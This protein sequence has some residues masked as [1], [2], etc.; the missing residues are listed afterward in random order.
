MIYLFWPTIRPEIFKKTHLEWKNK[1]TG[2][3]TT[4][5]GVNSHNELLSEYTIKVV[6][7]TNGVAK[8]VFNLTNDYQF[9]ENDIIIIPSDDMYPP[10]GWDKII[11]D[12][13][14]ETSGCLLINDCCN[15]N[16]ELITLPILD[17]NSFL[18][19]NR[20]IYHP[21][22][23]HLYADAELYD[24]AKKLGLI[25]ERR[26]IRFPH[27]H[28]SRGWIK[29]DNHHASFDKNLVEDQKNYLLRKKLSIDKK[30]LPNIN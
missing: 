5:V 7:N 9:F 6:G 28:W 22:Y 8:A 18:K 29:K 20:I 12:I 14:K 24:N 1:A 30:L 3:F 10:M 16:P 25:L 21:S 11:T 26:D 27:K 2:E 4:I 23:N 13:Y 17:Y 15:L 19:L